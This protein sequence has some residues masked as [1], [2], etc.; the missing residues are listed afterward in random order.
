[1]EMIAVL[2]ILACVQALAE[3]LPV[4]SSGHLVL[5]EHLPWIGENMR[6]IGEGLSLFVN[7]MLHVATLIAVVVYV[8]RDIAY[9][10]KGAWVS[11]VHR[12]MSSPDMRTIAYIIIASVPAGVIGVLFHHQIESLFSSPKLVAIMLVVNGLVLLSTKYIKIRHRFIGEAGVG[13]ALIIGI[14]QALAIVPGISRS[15]LTIAGGFF[16]GLEPVE[17]AKFS[18]FMAIPVIAGAGV[19]EGMK[20]AKAGLPDG[21]LVSLVLA[22]AVATILALAALHLLM[23]FVRKIRIDVF[24]YYTIAVGITGLVYFYVRG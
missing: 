6:A 23:H 5:V 13:R 10:A 11:I 1:M 9:L 3:F 24:G 16:M 12:E 2:F 17:A 20:A 21:F 7:V 22:M 14:C 19:F 18:F 15:G 4:S 8:R